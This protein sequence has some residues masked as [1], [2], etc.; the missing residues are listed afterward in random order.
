MSLGK[1]LFGRRC[2]RSHERELPP[3]EVRAVARHAGGLV[4][5]QLAVANLVF[6]AGK[7]GS[8]V[9]H[10]VVDW[11]M[12]RRAAGRVAASMRYRT[13]MYVIDKSAPEGRHDA[14]A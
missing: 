14:G 3:A 10:L 13:M 7:L 11:K 9:T 8:L 6:P 12:V 1:W 5:E 4:R 2:E